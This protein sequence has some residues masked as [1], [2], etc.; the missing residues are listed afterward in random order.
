[1]SKYYTVKVVSPDLLKGSFGEPA[2]NDLICAELEET[3]KQM[4]EEGILAGG[5]FAVK[6]D[7]PASLPVAGVLTHHLAHLYDVV[8]LRD[9]K[10]TVPGDQEYALPDGRVIKTIL[11]AADKP[12]PAF[13]VAVSHSSRHKV[14]DIIG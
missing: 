12:I 13:V 14:G 3:L 1:M 10:V 4:K 2:Q 5:P 8:A 9:P 7:G 6:F 11:D